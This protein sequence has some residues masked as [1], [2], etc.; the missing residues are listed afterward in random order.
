MIAKL[1]SVGVTGLNRFALDGTPFGAGRYRL[2][3]IAADGAESAPERTV[4]FRLT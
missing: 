1:T 4:R 2:R 3:V